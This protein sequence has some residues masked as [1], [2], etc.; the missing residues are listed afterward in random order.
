MTLKIYYHQLSKAFFVSFLL[1]G[2]QLQS[3]AQEVSVWQFRHV[4]Q[5]NMQ[6]F[7][8]RETKYWSKVAEAAVEKGNLTF[9]GLFVK[10]GGFNL[11]ESPNVIFINTFKDIDAVNMAETW[12]AS[13][14]FPDVPM[15]KM[16]T[17]S[18]SKTLHMFYVAPGNWVEKEGTNP[19]E[20]YNFIRFIFHNSDAPGQLLQLE[21]EHWAPFIKSAIDAGKTKQL[22]WGNARILA[23]SGPNMD[24]N[25]IS[26][27]IYPDMKTALMG[28]FDADADVEFP[29]EGLQKIN[30]LEIT[31][32]YDN[33]YRIVHVVNA[34]AS[35]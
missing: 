15:E 9:W 17:G 4:E 14:V 1:L 5:S 3:A 21:N 34:N 29:D 11:Q 23:P 31:R 22:A 8:E 26:Y 28:G 6:E 18:I 25:T 35:E 20:D 13:A 33:V 24:A 30:D 2:I 7:I 12:N 32:R 16:Q 10:Q 27:D 19:T